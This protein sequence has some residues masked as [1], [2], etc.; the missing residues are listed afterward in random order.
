M[1]DINTNGVT[2]SLPA[3]AEDSKADTNHDAGQQM[4]P[5]TA[6]MG[7]PGDLTHEEP[8]AEQAQEQDGSSMSSQWL[9]KL[10]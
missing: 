6:A 2:G 9:S 8:P 10:E 5:A 1:A 7:R 3:D 4:I